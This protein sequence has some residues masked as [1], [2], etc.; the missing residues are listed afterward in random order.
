MS[1]LFAE[2]ITW[3]VVCKVVLPASFHLGMCQTYSHGLFKSPTPC[4]MKYHPRPCGLVLD[5][6]RV[7]VLCV[8]DFTAFLWKKSSGLETVVDW[9]IRLCQGVGRLRNALTGAGH[10]GIVH[11]LTFPLTHHLFGSSSPTDR[12]NPNHQLIGDKHPTIYGL[13]TILLV[14]GF[15]NHPQAMTFMTTLI[16][17][18]DGYPQ[19][20]REMRQRSCTPIWALALRSCRTKAWWW[21]LV[22]GFF[23]WTL[24]N[25]SIGHE[26]CG[27]MN[28]QEG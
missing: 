8:S 22:L 27:S 28:S 13:S 14:V 19:V 9:T 6:F 21:R 7:P 25:W 23:R 12:R 2:A 10:W 1:F 17:V 20:K 24:V 5:F 26:I 18:S 15:R 16:D 11:I 4:N 3:M